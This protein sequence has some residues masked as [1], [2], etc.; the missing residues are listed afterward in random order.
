MHQGHPV[1]S[2]DSKPGADSRFAE[3]GLRR[4]SP[5]SLLKSI[6]PILCIRHFQPLRQMLDIGLSQVV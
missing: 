2:I 3:P 6:K 1:V 4:W 5:A